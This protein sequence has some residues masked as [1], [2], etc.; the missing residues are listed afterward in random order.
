MK[1]R[2]L[3]IVVVCLVILATLPA[4]LSYRVNQTLNL[5]QP[6]V[7]YLYS[8]GRFGWADCEG[9]LRSWIRYDVYYILEIMTETLREFEDRSHFEKLL[10]DKAYLQRHEAKYEG[11]LNAFTSKQATYEADTPPYFCHDK[12]YEIH[13]AMNRMGNRNMFF[14][15]ALLEQDREKATSRLKG[16]EDVISVILGQM[17][18]DPQLKPLYEDALTQ[19]LGNQ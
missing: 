6:A 13:Q 9:N 15:A 3:V 11:M 8:F 4:V 5:Y 18:E 17:V 7:T 2:I 10:N 12:V 14:Y 16:I 1:Q 19:I